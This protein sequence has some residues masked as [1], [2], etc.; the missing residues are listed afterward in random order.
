MNGLKIAIAT[1]PSGFVTV[2]S[3]LEASKVSR[4]SRLDWLELGLAA[5]EADESLHDVGVGGMPDALGRM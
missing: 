1:G 2:N 3:I 4:T 5:A